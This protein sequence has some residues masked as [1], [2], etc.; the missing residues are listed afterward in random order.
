MGRPVILTGEMAAWP[1]LTRWTP[2]YLKAAIGDRLIE[3][4]GG[5]TGNQRFER[6]KDVHRREAP[7]DVVI[8]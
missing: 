7:F 8:D 4:Q 6:D 1:A 3:F 2:D 5:R